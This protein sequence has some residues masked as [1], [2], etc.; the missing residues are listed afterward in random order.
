MI[1][2]SLIDYKA[3][4]EDAARKFEELRSCL[5]ESKNTITRLKL[6][7]NEQVKKIKETQLEKEQA[8]ASLA[9]YK[10]RLDGLVGGNA[11]ERIPYMLKKIKDSE[12]TE[13][14]LR[15]QISRLYERI[16]DLQDENL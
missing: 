7:H 15:E 6:F 1:H 5:E 14:A 2:I 8:E 12:E 4:C 9:E 11:L 16:I 3:L 13:K 10:E